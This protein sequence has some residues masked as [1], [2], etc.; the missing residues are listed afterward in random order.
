MASTS[1][2]VSLLLALLCVCGC[3]GSGLRHHFYKKSCP[4]AEAT[5][6]H[7]VK[8]Y[9]AKDRTLAAPLLRMNFHDCFVRGCDGSVLLNSTANNSAEKAAIPNLSLRGYEV[10]DA[11]KEELE[12]K[13]PGVVSCADILALVAR[14]AV[15]E[16]SGG[17]FWRV[18]TGRRDGVI[19]R[20]N[21]VLTNLPPPF[22]NFSQLQA[23]FARKGLSVKD[24]VVLS[25]GH[26]IGRGHCPGF[27][28]RLYNFTGKGDM[29]PSLDS[30]YAKF[31]K[32]QCTSLA[33]TTTSV[34]M[35]PHSSLSLDSHYFTTLEANRGLF[36]SDAALL[37]NSVAKKLVDHQVN[38][39]RFF[40]NFKHSMQK[41]SEIEV[42]T[43]NDGQIRRHCAFIN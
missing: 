21:E 20:Q 9:I 17:P 11:T 10:I 40:R 31:L 4:S 29:D 2:I 30:T 12:K 43:G 33:D 18:R 41:M 39:K 15:L 32:K 8:K 28:N 27:S 14:D 37:T 34:E 25:G 13:C 22:F 24:L 19:S 36:Q 7:V 35:D 38:K 6:E 3:E 16:G 5:V 23:S 1:I 42:L 26:S